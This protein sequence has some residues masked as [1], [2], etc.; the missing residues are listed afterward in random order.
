MS[1]LNLFTFLSIQLQY[2]LLVINLILYRHV[3]LLV[4]EFSAIL[5]LSQIHI[6]EVLSREF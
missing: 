5:Y 3:K 4:L 2:R 1:F 6:L